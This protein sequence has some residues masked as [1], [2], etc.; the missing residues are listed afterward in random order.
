GVG[1]EV[2]VEEDDEG[3][4]GGEEGEGEEE[5]EVVGCGGLLDIEEMGGEKEGGCGDAGRGGG[6]DESDVGW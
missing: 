1:G 3:G 5:E 4:K 6:E 2:V